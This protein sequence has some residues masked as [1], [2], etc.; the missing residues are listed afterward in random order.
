V[1]FSIMHISLHLKC[2]ISVCNVSFIEVCEICALL[3]Y[4]VASCGNCFLMFQDNVSVPSSWVK[5]VRRT[6]TLE[7]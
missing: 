5:S 3:R 6:Q 2:T 1:A 7:R 4:Y